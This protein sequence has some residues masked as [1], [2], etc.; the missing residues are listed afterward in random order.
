MAAKQGKGAL[1]E[2]WAAV[3]D[4]MRRA[5]PP[6]EVRKEITDCKDDLKAANGVAHP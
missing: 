5:N 2:E 3:Y 4:D 1:Q 6:A